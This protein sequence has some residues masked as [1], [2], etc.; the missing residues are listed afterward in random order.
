ME[1][2]FYCDKN[3]FKISAHWRLC[4]VIK[5]QKN[6]SIPQTMET[7]NTFYDFL[8]T[9]FIFFNNYISL[10]DR[11]IKPIKFQITYLRPWSVFVDYFSCLVSLAVLTVSVV[12]RRHPWLAFRLL[13]LEQFL[14][15][16]IL[17]IFRFLC[18]IGGEWE[19]SIRM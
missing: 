19:I 10:K 11:P 14:I 9:I 4:S 16:N 7:T 15:I 2:V 3:L 13:Y 12:Q 6:V 5:P 8:L 18:S 17:I 1:S